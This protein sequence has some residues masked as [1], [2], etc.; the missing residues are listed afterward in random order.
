MSREHVVVGL[1]IGT[2]TTKVLVAAKKNEQEE[3]E[4]LSLIQEPSLG[5]RK[6]VVFNI[7]NVSEVSQLAVKKA[8]EESGQK[9]N[10]IYVNIGGAHVFSAFSHGLVSVSRADRKIPQE[11]VDRV[12]QSAQ[13]VSMPLSSSS[14]RQILKTLPK[15]FIVDGERGL[16]EVVGMEG[17]RLEADVLAVGVFSPYLN[18]LTKAVADA[19]LEIND[20]TPST[21]ASARAVLKKKEKELGVILVEI[22]AGT[23]GIAAYQEGDLV[24]TYVLPIGSSHITND[25]AAGLK[26]DVELAEKIKT[27]FGTCLHRGPDKKEKIE[28]EEDESFVLSHKQVAEIVGVR[29]SEIFNEVNKELKKLP[30]EM[31]FPGGVVITGGGAKLPR[32]IELAK[33]ELKMYCRIGKPMGF[34][35]GQDDTSLATVCGLVLEGFDAEMGEKTTRMSGGGMGVKVKNFFKNFI[36]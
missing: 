1:D 16:K 35:P 29:V 30:K 26:I 9:I 19:E 25:I 33:K 21:M 7:E 31:E 34:M 14:N 13:T 17:A 12:L 18:N 11:D 6:G 10:S 4:V 5:V 3:L 2:N 32:I 15:E 28:L 24:Y 27:E 22:G 36:P 20:V 8:R 23:T